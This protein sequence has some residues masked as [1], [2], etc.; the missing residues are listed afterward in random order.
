MRANSAFLWRLPCPGCAPR[1]LLQHLT[2]S[3]GLYVS[4]LLCQPRKLST[5]AKFSARRITRGR[6]VTT[7]S[8]PAL[9]EAK[10]R[11]Q[12]PRHGAAPLRPAL[13]RPPSRAAGFPHCR[14]PALLPRP[15]HTARCRSPAGPPPG[16]AL[17][18]KNTKKSDMTDSDDLSQTNLELRRDP[19]DRE[20][21]RSERSS[22]PA[23]SQGSP[24]SFPAAGRC[25][26]GTRCR[27]P[28]SC[29]CVPTPSGGRGA[30]VPA[31]P[32]ASVSRGPQP[33]GQRSRPG[34]D[35]RTAPQG[36]AGTRKDPQGSTH[37]PAGIRAQPRRDPRT[38]PQGS[39]HGP[40]GTPRTAPQGSA[41]SPAGIRA[42][43]RRDP[44]TDPQGSTH[45]PAG[46]HARAR[47]DPPGPARTRRDPRTAPRGPAGT[48]RD[49]RTAPQGPAHSPAGT[50]ARTRRD[51]RPAAEPSSGRPRTALRAVQP[52]RSSGEPG[53]LLWKEPKW[54]A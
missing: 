45:G 46:I 42:Q 15:P 24:G 17:R 25:R 32:G 44:R 52:Q 21:K 30:A 36:P 31:L 41:H 39:T 20:T 26:A 10:G 29:P 23:L 48:R 40:A 27:P 54:L 49:P 16:L 35:P 2:V 12:S 50:R 51:P 11:Q 13:L 38:D 18:R 3:A 7:R 4:L 9:G 22:P 1:A 47:R 34:R 14:S 8:P 19:A 43:P 5:T 53:T 37:G 6:G 33:A 28:R